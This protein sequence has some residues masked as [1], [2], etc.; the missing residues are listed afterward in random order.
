MIR[1][2]PR[3]TL[4]PYTTLFRSYKRRSWSAKSINVLAL[5]T[6]LPPSAETVKLEKL[7][8]S[9][10]YRLPP[11]DQTLTPIGECG[12]EIVLRK[13]PQIE[14]DAGGRLPK[15][16]TLSRAEIYALTGLNVGP[17]PA[18]APAPA[19]TPAPAP[20]PAAPDIGE[21]LNRAV[22]AQQARNFPAAEALYREVLA[23]SPDN[24]D[25]THL[26]GVL[27]RQRGDS[28]LAVGQIRKALAVAPR[29]A[30]AY[31]NLG[32]ALR[33]V[34]RFDEALACYESRRMPKRISSA[35]IFCAIWAST[36]RRPAPTAIR[37]P[38]AQ[39]MPI[40]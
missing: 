40:R 30:T 10:R 16:G 8:A 15:Q 36:K 26:L 34:K 19:P 1:R 37:S 13:R 25:A 24:F 27:Y 3:S 5:L 4:F 20:A 11:L 7:D 14:V 31:G 18:P 12:I 32:N 21:L 39:T 6:Q 28:A 17:A 38:C 9:Y 23:L 35:A 2:P 29:S 33:D 22:A